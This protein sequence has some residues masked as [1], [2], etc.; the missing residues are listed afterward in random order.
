L[1]KS[2]EI[3]KTF[4]I[5]IKLKTVIMKKNLHKLEKIE[6]LGN[7]LRC[8]YHE[9]SL[10][11]IGNKY[12]EMPDIRVVRPFIFANTYF[13]IVDEKKYK[14][15]GCLAGIVRCNIMPNGVVEACST[16]KVFGHY[17][18]GKLQDYSMDFDS[19]WTSEKASDTRKQIKNCPGCPNHCERG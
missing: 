5:K 2:I 12:I 7:E 9:Y 19:I 11:M 8:D 4:G 13:R 6:K 10:Q 18:L 15:A 3:L 1:V 17:I 16:S 14:G